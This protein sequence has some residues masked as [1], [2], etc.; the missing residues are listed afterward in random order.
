MKAWPCPK[1]AGLFFA[2]GAWYARADATGKGTSMPTLKIKNSEMKVSTSLVLRMADRMHR[3]GSTTRREGY[4][5][6]AR[7]RIEAGHFHKN[8]AA[9]VL[10]AGG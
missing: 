4:V 8:D 2:A 1:S 9:I 5:A 7:Q 6:R 3:L 10:A